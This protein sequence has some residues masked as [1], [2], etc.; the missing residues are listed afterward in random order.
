MLGNSESI[1]LPSTKTNVG[2]FYSRGETTRHLVS[3]CDIPEHSTSKDLFDVPKLAAYL[4]CG[5]F[6]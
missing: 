3:V 4:I 6:I 5:L 2:D 1:A